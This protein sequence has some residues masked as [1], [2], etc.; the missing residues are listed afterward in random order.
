MLIKIIKFNQLDEFYYPYRLPNLG[1][2]QAGA[3]LNS[4]RI[5]DK[6]LF[7]IAVIKYGIEYK[8]MDLSM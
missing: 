7:M 6:Q 8:E 2:V 3:F 5:I 4:Y 1:I